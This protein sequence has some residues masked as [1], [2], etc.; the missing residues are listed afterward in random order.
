MAA[1]TSVVQ[2]AT[3]NRR[4]RVRHR[5]QTPAYATFVGDSKSAMLDL[6]EILNVSEEGVA[7]QCPA[8]IEVGKR[9]NLC[10]DLAECPDHI[11]TSG[12]VIWSNESGRTGLRFAELPPFSVFRLREWLFL[13]AVAAVANADDT[14]ASATPLVEHVPPRP[15]YTDMLA[16]VTAVQRE[17]EA[18]GPDLAAALQLIAARTQTLIH[19]TGA[20]VALTDRE[21]DFMVCAASAGPDAPPVGAPDVIGGHLKAVPGDGGDARVGFGK[22]IRRGVVIAGPF[23]SQRPINDNKIG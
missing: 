2:T 3:P 23:I 22:G 6:H 13:N 4:R 18:L 11:Y 14:T 9:F 20:A 19:A 16:A 8:P 15:S 10:L 21:P 7:I 17:V 1:S 12:Q 5:I